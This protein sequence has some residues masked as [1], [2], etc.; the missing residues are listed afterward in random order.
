M[1]AQGARNREIANVLTISEFTVKRHVQN[2]LQ[3]LEL[4]SR[5]AAGAFYR[6]AV[7]QRESYAYQGAN[8]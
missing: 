7:E 6:S 4:A 2:I 5:T 1:V 8:A 3:K